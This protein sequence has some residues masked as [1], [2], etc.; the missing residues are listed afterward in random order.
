[1]HSQ[2]KMRSRVTAHAKFVRVLT[3]ILLNRHEITVRFSKFLTNIFGSSFEIPDIHHELRNFYNYAVIKKIAN[4][5]TKGSI[6]IE[7][8]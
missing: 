5:R 6:W 2:A 4:L 8:N 1:M 3:A 7:K